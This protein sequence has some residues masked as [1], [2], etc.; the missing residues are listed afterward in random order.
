MSG[1][2][3]TDRAHVINTPGLPEG[4]QPPS[5]SLSP[6]PNPPRART[7]DQGPN[8]D[9]WRMGGYGGK[10]RLIPDA[11]TG[12]LRPYMR[13]STFAKT[14]DD[15]FG[16]GVWKAWMAV[17]GADVEKALRE[18]ALHADRTP[19]KVIDQLV[20]AGG[21]GV[22]R[23]KG[24]DRHTILQIA[25]TGGTL[26]KLPVS[27]RAELDKILRL[28]DTIGVVD[29]VEA[30]CVCDDW[31][32]AGT[33]DLRL[34]APNGAPVI[35]DFKTGGDY[36]LA[37]AIQLVAYARSRLWDFH[38][39]TRAEL[40]APVLPRLVIIHAP[41]D[42]AEPRAIVI[43]PHKAREAADLAWKVRSLR[44]YFNA[45]QRQKEVNA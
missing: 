23:D 33:M 30:P 11:Q 45:K 20:D 21:G 25:L 5:A 26:P 27:A 1:D 38:T 39:E 35:A 6:P 40:V 28:I 36:R 13:V 9:S 37:A 17:R 7:G 4:Y 24:K 34:T 42:G 22:K 16:L 10:Q 15:G 41:Q 14:L 12:E 31:Q 44:A 2:R 29:F 32:L 8:G 3:V 43:D 18:Q 19:A